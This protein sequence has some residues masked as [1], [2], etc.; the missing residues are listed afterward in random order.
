MYRDFHIPFWIVCAKIAYMLQVQ[1]VNIRDA[2][3]IVVCKVSS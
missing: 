3:I 1:I 2:G